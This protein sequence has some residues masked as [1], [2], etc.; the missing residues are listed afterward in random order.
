MGVVALRFL[1][2][3]SN[4]TI[5]HID[6]QRELLTALTRTVQHPGVVATH[7][8][9]RSYVENKAALT[10]ARSASRRHTQWQSQASAILWDWHAPVAG[11]VGSHR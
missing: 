11:P 2:V 1:S 4:A 9:V 8:L 5:E 3:V 6:R 10:S 7:L